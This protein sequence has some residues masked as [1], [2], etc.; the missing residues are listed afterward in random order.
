MELTLLKYHS[1]RCQVTACNNR[2]KQLLYRRE[3]HKAPPLGL[4]CLQYILTTLIPDRLEFCDITLQ[5]VPKVRYSNFM[6]YNFD[7]NY[8]LHEIARRCL[9]L[10]QVH[11]FRISVSGVPFLFFYHIL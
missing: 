3:Y 4:F 11:V 1:N 6:H 10:Y 9:F 2:T 5:G 7:Q 8:I